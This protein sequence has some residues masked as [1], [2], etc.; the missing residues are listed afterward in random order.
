M[1][2]DFTDRYGIFPDPEV[3]RHIGDGLSTREEELAYLMRCAVHWTMLGCGYWIVRDMKRGRS[4]GEVGFADHRS[5][6]VS[7]LLDAPPVSWAL[8][9]QSMHGRGYAA[10]AE[11]AAPDRVA[12]C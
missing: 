1:L 8:A 3:T 10:E 5:E 9:V 4:V 7:P 11:R 12:G 2:E 6:L